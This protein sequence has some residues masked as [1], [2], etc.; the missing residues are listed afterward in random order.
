MN[1]KYWQHTTEF[2]IMIKTTHFK[3]SFCVSSI[4]C[5]FIL[6]IVSCPVVSKQT[7]PFSSWLLIHLLQTEARPRPTPKLWDRDRGQSWGLEHLTSLVF[8]CVTC[9]VRQQVLWS[10]GNDATCLYEFG[11]RSYTALLKGCNHTYV[12]GNAQNP[13]DS[14][15]HSFTV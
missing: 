14:F 12:H 10:R 2:I 5:P 15:P 1:K 11:F 4:I 6:S 8:T 3:F 13:V 7:G 9:F